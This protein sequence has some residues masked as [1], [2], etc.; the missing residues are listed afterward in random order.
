MCD[1]LENGPWPFL[2]V[3]RFKVHGDRGDVFCFCFHVALSAVRRTGKLLP[4]ILIPTTLLVNVFM[5]RPPRGG[6]LYGPKMDAF[7]TKT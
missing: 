2:R 3:G 1:W 6:P 7:G 5:G 4:A